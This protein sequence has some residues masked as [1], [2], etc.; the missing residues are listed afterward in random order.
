MRDGDGKFKVSPLDL[1][2]SYRWR[3]VIKQTFHHLKS[4]VDIRPIYHRLDERVCA[5]VL[6]C[7]LGYLLNRTVAGLYEELAGFD[8][9]EI[10][11]NG[12]GLRGHKITEATSRVR[13]IAKILLS[14]DLLNE[15]ILVI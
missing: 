13:N 4:F 3:I 5:H 8:A 9:C 7:I 12:L 11:I 10:K 14:E 6:V 15:K 1:A 2:A